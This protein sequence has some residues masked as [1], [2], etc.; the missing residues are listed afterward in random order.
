MGKLADLVVVV[1]D[2]L[3]DVT[4][5]TRIALVAKEGVVHRD[6]AWRRAPTRTISWRPQHDLLDPGAG[7]GDGPSSAYA[8]QSHFFGVGRLVG[9][10]EPGLGGV[11][12][13]AFVNVGFGPLGLASLRDGASAGETLDALV[14]SDELSAYR[15]VAVVDATGEVARSPEGCACPPPAAGRA[16]RSSPRATC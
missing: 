5:L 15:Q 3:E 11:A 12:T 7:P 16:T 13:Q 2:P 6:N 9:W 8:C 1:G 14:A 4:A 10:L